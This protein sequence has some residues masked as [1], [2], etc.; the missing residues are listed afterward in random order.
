MKSPD[1]NRLAIL[2]ATAL[3]VIVLAVVG[4]ALHCAG[5]DQ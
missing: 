5:I 3:A 1:E 4:I 2:Y